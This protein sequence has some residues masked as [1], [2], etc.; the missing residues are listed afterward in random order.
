MTDLIAKTSD[1]PTIELPSRL[2]WS[3]V[4]TYS[5]CG[6]KWLLERGFKVQRATWFA[7][8]A[9][10]VIHEITEAM[11]R[12]EA[13]GI[14]LDK[15]IEYAPSFESLFK[16]KLA[17]EREKGTEILASGRRLKEIGAT[18]GPNKKDEEWWLV[19]GPIFVERWIEWKRQKGWRV[20]IMPDGNPGIELKFEVVLGGV[21]VLGYIDRVYLLADGSI[22]VVDLKGLALDTPIPTPTGWTTMGEVQVGDEVLSE[23]GKPVV[24]CAKSQPK[25]IGTYVVTFDDGA[26]ITC[27]SEHIWWTRGALEKEPS[28]KSIEYIRD[29]LFYGK[30]RQHAVPIAGPLELPEADLPIEPY[31]LG[32]WLGDGRVRGGEICKEDA[33]FDLLGEDGHALGSRQEYEGRTAITRTVLGLAVQLKAAGL[34]GN[35]HIPAVYLRASLDQRIALLR[36]LMDT[37]GT[38]NRCRNRVSFSSTDEGLAR[39]VLELVHTLGERA[40]L[41]THLAKGFGL[42]VRAYSVEWRA[43]QFNPFRMARKADRV[44]LSSPGKSRRRLIVDV[45]PGPDVE[46]A[47]IAVD[48]PSHLYLCGEE[49]IPTH[50]TGTMPSGSLQLV[51]YAAGLEEQYGLSADWACFWSPGTDE[52]GTMS[53]PIAIPNWSLERLSKMYGDAYRGIRSGVFL[54]QVT[55]MCKGCTVRDSCWAVAGSKAEDL[56][57]HFDILDTQTGEIVSV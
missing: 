43:T 55:A 42:E 22:C 38:W 17:E 25:R 12:A 47:C 24:V 39:S 4:S 52:G 5:D 1:R 57:T 29:T 35:K 41:S 33:L 56:P 15:Q 31:L 10:S 46:T 26:K 7:T 36:G 50:N 54:P 40:H 21:P 34:Y 18:G 27:D 9:G 11:D 23:D 30:Q 45:Q 13:K 20:A 19:Y 49:M 2:S 16:Q 51:T 28:P 53:Q 44:K 32:A 14:P 48:S 8:I 37:D 3:S 6:T